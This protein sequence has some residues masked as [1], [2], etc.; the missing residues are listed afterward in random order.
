MSKATNHIYVKY[1]AAFALCSFMGNPASSESN[2]LDYWIESLVYEIKQNTVF[3]KSEHTHPKILE[4]TA[5]LAGFENTEDFLNIARSGYEISKK[6][7]EIWD[8]SAV[9]ENILQGSAENWDWALVPI[10]SRAKMVQS[11]DMLPDSCNVHLFFWNPKGWYRTSISGQTSKIAT[12]SAIPELRKAVYSTPPTCLVSSTSDAGQQSPVND[13]E[14]NKK[15]ELYEIIYG[16]YPTNCTP[17][18]LVQKNSCIVEHISF[19]SNDTIFITQDKEG[20]AE[21]VNYTYSSDGKIQMLWG[22][23]QGYPVWVDIPI[24][25]QNGFIPIAALKENRD[26]SLTERRRFLAPISNDDLEYTLKA[27]FSSGE[28]LILDGVKLLSV[29]GEYT[30]NYPDK[31]TNMTEGF[32]IM[33][34]YNVIIEG[35]KSIGPVRDETPREIL[36]TSQATSRDE[37]GKYQCR[38]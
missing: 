4:E 30:Y 11:G 10:L 12:V 1:F 6:Q 15:K 29:T 23:Y 36:R 31:I 24:E 21:K 18:F 9:N 27:E 2:K 32:F 26:G 8:V 16:N 33:T 37:A 5:K 35:T 22:S 38:D 7:I 17:K 13:D 34:D 20:S 14:I 19:C 28:S 3:E 25:E